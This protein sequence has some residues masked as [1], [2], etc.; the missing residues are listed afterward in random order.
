MQYDPQEA[1]GLD[2]MLHRLAGEAWGPLLL[3]AVALGLLA[4]AAFCVA[5]ARFRRV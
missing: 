4:Y 5:Q 3:A 2:E 1:A